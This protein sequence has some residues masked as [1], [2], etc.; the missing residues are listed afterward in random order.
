M[1]EI[2]TEAGRKAR[3]AYLREYRRRKKERYHDSVTRHWNRV[4]AQMEAE[5]AKR[6]EE[7]AEKNE[8]R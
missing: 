3:N 5:E 7:E 4:G 1:A 2:L 8:A 6:K